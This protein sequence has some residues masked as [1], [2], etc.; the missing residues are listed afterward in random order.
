MLEFVVIGI[1]V[2]V[3]TN[4][5]DFLLLLLFFGNRSYSIREIVLGQY[6]GISLLILIS[7]ILS[8]VSLI[9]P[10]SWIGLMGFLPILIGLW[11][12]LKR[13]SKTYN[14]NI[15]EKLIQKNKFFGSYRSKILAVAIVIFSSGGDNIGV[16]VPLFA[17]HTIGQVLLFIAIF[18]L[19]TSVWCFVSYYIT[20]HTLAGY[21]IRRYGHIILPFALIGLGV[22]ILSKSIIF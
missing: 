1:F 6:L 18:M 3:I 14:E 9:I 8:L 2:F 4:L 16:Y 12:L 13:R 10:A 19:F 15:I 5:D 17:I 7:G 21:K 20:N 22:W 11:Q